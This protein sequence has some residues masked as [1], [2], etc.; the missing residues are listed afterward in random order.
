ML[1]PFLVAGANKLGIRLLPSAFAHVLDDE[2]STDAPPAKKARTTDD[3]L[4]T[5]DA[6]WTN[7]GVDSE[8]RWNTFMDVLCKKLDGGRLNTPEEPPNLYMAFGFNKRGYSSYDAV[9]RALS[10]WCDANDARHNGYDGK[11]LLLT[12]G[13][14]A[15]GH[16][17]LE[18]IASF[19]QRRGTPVVF[20]ASDFAYATPGSP[21]W[22]AYASAGY[23]GPGRRHAIPKLDDDGQP[24][25]DING[26][27]DYRE[28]WGGYVHDANGVATTELSF[29]DEAVLHKSF[30]G[31]QLYDHLGGIFAAGGGDVTAQQ[32]D[33][34]GL[35]SGKRTGDF[36]VPASD[37][38]GTNSPLSELLN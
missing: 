33:I 14:F 38:S 32:A 31:R 21:E 23:F 13:D 28:C 12:H 22:P 3:T 19:V 2:S 34:Y 16:P 11:W 25:Q 24:L 7:H 30:G 37:L 26:E 8:S 29:P 15:V 6:P 9:E 20:L 35:L 27:V 5:L 36:F 18:T 17:S 10:G 4:Y 1:L